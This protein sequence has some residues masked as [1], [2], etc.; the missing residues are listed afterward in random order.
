MRLDLLKVTKLPIYGRK[1][2][3]EMPEN[4]AQLLQVAKNIDKYIIC[5]IIY[6]TGI[7]LCAILK[8]PLQF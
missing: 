2:L 4:V 6:F 3:S 1:K 5:G 7:I 8:L